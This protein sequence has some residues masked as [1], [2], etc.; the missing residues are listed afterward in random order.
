MRHSTTSDKKFLYKCSA[1]AFWLLVWQGASM[2]IDQEILLASPAA[3]LGRLW[4]LAPQPA[5]REIVLRSFGRIVS[6]FF[7]ALGAGTLAAALSYRLRFA[8]ELLSPL[9]L[10][11]KATPVASFIILSLVW[12]KGSTLSVFISFL[13]VF[14]IVYTNLL[15]G[16]DCTDRKLLEMADVFRI[17]PWRRVCYI[18]SSQVMPYFLSACTVSLG[19]CWKSGI[20]AEVIG[21]P[22]G[23]IGEQLYNAKIYLSTP[24]L[25]AWTVVIILISLLFEKC[26]LFILKKLYYRLERL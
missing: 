3:V 6:G 11:V 22:R 9:I 21:I 8:R 7:L 15:K 4:D 20:A 2:A 26:F 19:L 1:I 24:D 17:G 18:Y 12:L 13:M 25:F 10:V 14:P 16:L 23:S 5:F